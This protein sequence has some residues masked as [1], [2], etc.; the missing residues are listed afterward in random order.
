MNIIKSKKINLAFIIKSKRL[1]S[2]FYPL[3]KSRDF[4]RFTKRDE[5]LLINMNA[6]VKSMHKFNFAKINCIVQNHMHKFNFFVKTAYF[7]INIICIVKQHMQFSTQA[8]MQRKLPKV[9][10][11]VKTLGSST[12]QC[13]WQR[14][15]CAV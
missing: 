15:T 14:E 13:R 8:N 7:K 3:C 10:E 12:V 11:E 6:Q 5:Y 4:S 2:V 9:G 1:E